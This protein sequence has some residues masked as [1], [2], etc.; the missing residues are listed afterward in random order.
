MTT[1]TIKP[2]KSMNY[3]WLFFGIF[4][5]IATI[6]TLYVLLF[7]IP[8]DSGLPKSTYWVLLVFVAMAVFSFYKMK[9]QSQLASLYLTQESVTNLKTKQTILW[10]NLGDLYFFSAGKVIGLAN[11]LA[12]RTSK[13]ESFEK[14]TAVEYNINDLEIFE[15]FHCQPRSLEV[16]NQIQ[17]GKTVAFS[18]LP[19]N[20]LKQGFNLVASQFLTFD[21]DEILLN[22]KELI[23]KNE[24]YSLQNLSVIGLGNSGKYQLKNQTGTSILEFNKLN[25]ISCEVFRNVLNQLVKNAIS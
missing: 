16:L 23:Y 22:N 6:G 8:S 2:S 20:T 7:L 1:Y 25:F 13:N 19:N 21:S 14:I 5:L 12:Y 18:F 11:N 24:T 10:K 4:F 17:N 9:N 3:A 15:S